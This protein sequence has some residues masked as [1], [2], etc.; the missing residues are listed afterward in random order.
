M[1][2]NGSQTFEMFVFQ[3]Y[4]VWRREQNTGYFIVEKNV[5]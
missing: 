1:K 2:G 5:T 3:R 4:R